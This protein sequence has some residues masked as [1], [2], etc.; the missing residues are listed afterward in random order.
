MSKNVFYE[1]EGDLKVGAI[2]ADNE[3]SLQVEAPHGKRSKVKASHVL[4]RFDDAR[5]GDFMGAA[6]QLAESLDVNFLWEC[7]GDAEF[8]YESLAQEYFGRRPGPAEA[9]ALL[10]KLHGAPMYFYKKGRGRYRAAPQDALKAALASVERKRREA[11][12]RVQYVAQLKRAEL[13]AEFAPHLSSLL[14]K[15]EKASIEWKA[16][17]EACEVLKLTPARQIERCGGIPSTHA[18]HLDRF[19]FE[20]FPRGTAF[21][22][23]PPLP[24]T[25]DLPPAGAEAFSIDD[26]STTEIDDAFSVSPLPNGNVSVGI[27]I[28]APAVGITP[29][30]PIDAIARER[31]STV[32]F[33]GAKITML[34][35]AVVERFSLTEDGDRPALSLY[36]ELAPDA[37][38]ISAATR[39]ERIPVAANLRHAE[40]ERVLD[41]DALAAG[42]LEHRYGK[43][44]VTLWRL[45][46]AL[47]RARRKDEPELEMRPEYNFYVEHDRVRI[48]RRQRGT[49]LD[50]IV[51]ELMIYANSAWGRQLAG[52][53]AA[54]IYRVQGAGKV[55]MS[56]VPAGHEGLGVESYA[57]ASSPLRRY[58][59]LVNQR[60]LLALTQGEALPYRRSD[61]ALLAAMRDF[62][63]AYEAYGEFQ[64][65]MERYWSLRWLM[66]EGVET[67]CAMVL[68]ESLARFEELPLVTRVPSL[69]ALAPGTRVE[70]AVSGIDLLELTLRC[71]YR[72]Q[73]P[74][75]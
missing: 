64:R 44:L 66:Q 39:V 32:Y 40:L 4:L 3:T 31:L 22:E 25:A 30:S 70:L 43:Q 1:E 74:E 12:K 50:K 60:Q 33:P 55:R 65:N 28:A 75:G 68:R 26:A 5:L 8:S 58:V 49:P 23:L 53:D 67:V 18:Y 46:S 16:L 35:E 36:L 27:H 21:P 19:L 15:P 24:A 72:R 51:S 41:A 9:A 59:D 10:I 7:C 69:P 17:E 61:E 63:S 13:P 20:H 62:E 38:V 42:R 57:W 37:S 52:A 71:E 29:S 6:R 56:T 48:V 34:P 54:A 14:Y 11:E 45:A 47:E 2:L 73:L